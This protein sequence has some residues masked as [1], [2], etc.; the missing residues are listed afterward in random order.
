MSEFFGE[1]FGTFV[2]ILLGNGVVANVNLNKTKSFGS[3]WIVITTGWA[4]AICCCLLTGDI[5]GTLIRL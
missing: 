5:R 3:G 2:M 1:F 4:L